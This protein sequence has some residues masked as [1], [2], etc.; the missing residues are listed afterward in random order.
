VH[1]G[2]ADGRLN[3]RACP[4][5]SCAVLAVLAESDRLELLPPYP[6]PAAWLHVRTSGGLTGWIS[7]HYCEVNP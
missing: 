6:T 5:L 2:L 7:A 3:L 4:G 1:T